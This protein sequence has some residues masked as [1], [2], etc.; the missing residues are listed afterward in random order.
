MYLNEKM[1]RN[2]VRI[3]NQDIKFLYPVLLN[4]KEL[5]NSEQVETLTD[6]MNLAFGLPS[7]ALPKKVAYLY[8]F[9][10]DI[11]KSNK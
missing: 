8:A 3:E 5:L 6:V 2:I 1:K 4:A 10:I 11:I 9:F 7:E